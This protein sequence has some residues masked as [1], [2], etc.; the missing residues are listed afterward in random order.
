MKPKT[1]HLT[2][3]FHA[4]SGGIS[5]FYRAL[6]RH[7]NERG[8]EMRLVAPGEQNGVQ[9]EGDFGRIYLVK[10]P[11]SPWIDPRYRLLMPLG[12]GGR[13]I[14]RILAEE[15][16]RI[17][18][19]SDKYSLPYISGL[20]RKGLMRGAP[21][22]TE[23]A[24]S[25]ER[26]DDNF[27]VHVSPG[28]LGGLFSRL[29]MRY[30]Y[31][32]QFDHHIA[33]SSYTA[34]EL[35]PASRGHTTRRGIWVC[36]MG[37][38][39]E[40]FRP[41][42]DLG[43]RRRGSLLYAGRLAREKNVSLLLDVLALLPGEFTL[44]IAG[45]GPEREAVEAR[46][47][48]EFPGRVRMLGFLKDRAAYAARL[49]EA[50]VFLHPNPREPFGIGPLEAMA[51]GAPTVVPNSGGVLSYANADNAWLCPADAAAFASAVLEIES[52]GVERRRRSANAVATAA[53]HDWR[54]IAERYFTLLDSLCLRGFAGMADPPMG[55]AIDAWIRA[56]AA[57]SQPA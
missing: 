21:R 3:F 16:P 52:D 44:D 36:P 5:A 23:I 14:Q 24:T 40:L 20:I 39:T 6:F 46:A 55:A 33:N 50:G 56:R 11:R 34:A 10:A 51:S 17:L 45:D 7:A 12:R 49:R 30:I 8:R 57:A 27:A 15:R 26:M 37:V 42:A 18:E 29:Y 41:A 4:S 9:S 28:R 13:E 43:R 35:A 25:H 54:L 53:A 1:V 32:A 22:P 19:V 2:N 47:R 31:F 38:D 48:A